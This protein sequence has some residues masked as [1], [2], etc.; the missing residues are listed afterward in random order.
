MK[1]D[2]HVH[3]SEI[4]RCGKVSAVDTVRMYKEAG[5]G[6]IVITNHFSRD[7]ERHFKSLGRDDYLNAFKE[8]F[9]LARAEGERLGITVLMGYELRFERNVNDYLV[10][11]LPDEVALEYD[12]IFKMSPS[13]FG[14]L[15]NHVGALFYQAHPFRNSMTVVN[16]ACLFGI[17]VVNG[18]QRHDS[19]ND[20]ANMWADKFS[21]HKIG[22]SDFHHPEDIAVSGIETNESITTMEELVKLLREGNYTVIGQ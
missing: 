3:T 8:G 11:G 16:P 15:A 22:G 20:I 21:L 14:S 9:E 13:E 12:R 1:I 5:Y 4:S 19:R 17:E 6:A 18:N 2:L 10:F 7:E